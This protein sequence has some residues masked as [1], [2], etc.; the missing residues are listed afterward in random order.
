M[1]KKLEVN[2]VVAWA[3]LNGSEYV[4]DLDIS[5]L[6]NYFLQ[7]NSDYVLGDTSLKNIENYVER[8][9]DKI[10]LKDDLR[11]GSNISELNQSLSEYLSS[12]ISKDFIENC[13]FRDFLLLKI[14]YLQNNHLWL[15]NFLDGN[16]KKILDYFQ[17]KG[18]LT[19]TKDDMGNLQNVSF[20]N[21]VRLHIFKLQNLPL[22]TKFQKAVEELGYNGKYIDEY[23]LSLK[24]DSSNPDFW[25]TTNFIQYMNENRSSYKKID[26]NEKNMHGLIDKAIRLSSDQSRLYICCLR[27]DLSY[28]DDVICNPQKLLLENDFYTFSKNNISSA[29]ELIQGYLNNP[30]DLGYD[31]VLIEGEVWANRTFLNFKGGIRKAG[32]EYYICSSKNVDRELLTRKSV[33]L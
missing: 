18:Y 12:L 9:N 6:L 29:R 15:E 2:Q 3:F 27:N 32:Q 4:S 26:L 19:I 23:F 16:Q 11:L 21:S 5:L 1:E 28:L 22:V 14:N 33:R 25:S 17:Y 13:S 10:Y 24:L 8:K 20:S 30:T 7:N 31:L